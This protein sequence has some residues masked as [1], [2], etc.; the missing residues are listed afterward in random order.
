[1]RALL[2]ANIEFSSRS[3]KTF[4][5]R[6][7]ERFIVEMQGVIR[8]LTHGLT[9][10]DAQERRDELRNLIEYPGTLRKEIASALERAGIKGAMKHG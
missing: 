10:G 1:M 9:M 5:L 8:T 4:C 7:R 6:C 2:R 3:V